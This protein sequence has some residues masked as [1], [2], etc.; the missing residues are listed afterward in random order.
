MGSMDEPSKSEVVGE[1][2]WM[3]PGRLL[4]L[5]DLPVS[6]AGARTDDGIPLAEMPKC[7]HSL[8]LEAAEWILQVE[9]RTLQDSIVLDVHWG[10]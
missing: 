3:A 1:V 9:R 6:I 5:G 7:K 10:F 2:L 4:C 8:Q